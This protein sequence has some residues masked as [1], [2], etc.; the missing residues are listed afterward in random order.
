MNSPFESRL[1]RRKALRGTLLGGVGAALLRPVADAGQGA[2]IPANSAAN[3]LQNVPDMVVAFT[4]RGRVELARQGETW[5]GSGIT[6]KVVANGV[7]TAILVQAPKAALMR[8]HLRWRMVLKPGLR[9]MGD[10]WERSYGDLAWRGLEPERILPWYFLASDGQHTLAAGVKTNPAAFSFWQVDGEGVNLW[11]DVRNGGNGVMLGERELKAATVIAEQY[12]GMSAFA[13]EHRLC[14]RLCDSPRLPK[15]PVY[16]GNDWYYAYGHNSAD[17]ILRDSGLIASLA[18][19]QRNRPWMV[20]DD[21]WQRVSTA[22]PWKEGNRRFPDMP[23][24]YTK[25]RAEGVKPG[26]WT[27]SLFTMDDVPKAWRLRSPATQENEGRKGGATLDPTVPEVAAM[28][29]ADIE[30]FRGWGYELIK[31]DYSTYDLLGR[32]GLAMGPQLTDDGWHFADRSKTTAEIIR[33]YYEGMRKAAGESLL[34]GCNAVGHLGAGLFDLQRIGD[35]TSG[36]DWN[37]TRKM[38]VNTLAF[39][40]AQHGAFFAVD[41]DC[42]GLTRDVPWALNRQWLD[43]VARSSTPLFVSAAPDALGPEQKA[44]L[45]AAFAT[46]AQAGATAE[47]LDWMDDSQPKRWLLRG[48]AAEYDWAGDDGASP[49]AK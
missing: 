23:A 18:G 34:L 15:Q 29:A 41:A 22:G 25:M 31:H 33:G 10:H 48:K 3:K 40:A 24:L 1:T 2:S 5:A 19:D 49:F 39:R 16:G 13:A 7:E 11:L 44:A 28:V 35:D 4:E 45:K 36:R 30:R 14:G 26:L 6:V 20:I 43:L 46:A 21:G 9:Y 27:R 42:V 37:R 17:G 8:I 47:P 38:G 12:D 32:W